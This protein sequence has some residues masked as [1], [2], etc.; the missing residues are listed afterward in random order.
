MERVLKMK[1]LNQRLL[2]EEI[3]DEETIR[4]LMKSEEDIE[5]GRTRKATEVFEELKEKYGFW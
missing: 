4:C 5:N 3:F 2:N 1:K